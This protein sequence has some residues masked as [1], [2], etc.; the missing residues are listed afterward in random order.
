MLPP[1]VDDAQDLSM[2]LTAALFQPRPQSTTIDSTLS[3]RN[4]C[5]HISFL[6]AHHIEDKT[7]D[8]N[9]I[10]DAG[11]SHH[12]LLNALPRQWFHLRDC[13]WITW[14]GQIVMTPHLMAHTI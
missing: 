5:T 9:P 8:A 14:H 1:M 2:P 3:I 13:T 10:C 7:E 11:M 6:L 12:G 4:V